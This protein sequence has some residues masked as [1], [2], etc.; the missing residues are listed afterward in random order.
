[1]KYLLTLLMFLSSTLAAAQDTKTT[2]PMYSIRKKESACGGYAIFLEEG[3]T[4]TRLSEK[5]IIL[6]SNK[7][8]TKVEVECTGSCS[9]P[10]G[11]FWYPYGNN[12]NNIECDCPSS[13]DEKKDCQIVVR[14]KP[15]N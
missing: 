4:A 3:T 9:S 6:N 12:P 11:C 8:V 15:W 1:M 10:G 14:E 5:V 7:S 13:T 2:D